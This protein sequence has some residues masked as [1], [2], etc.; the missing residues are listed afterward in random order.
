MS[1][2]LRDYSE[3]SHSINNSSGCEK[4]DLPRIVVVGNQSSGKSSVLELITGVD[5]LPRGT[6]IV[7]KVPLEVTL[8]HTEG[9]DVYAMF[10]HTKGKRFDDFKEVEREIENKTRELCGEEGKVVNKP[11]YLTIYSKNVP[12]LLLIDLPGLVDVDTNDT[13]EGVKDDIDRLVH[14][15]VE[16]ENTIIVVVSPVIIDSAN[17]KGL[18]KAKKVDPEMRRTI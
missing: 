12:N 17:C 16:P 3:V 1:S 8:I 9:E 7:T 14:H 5:F 10:R 11:I 15:Y 6:G 4:I 13:Y 2:Y 18:S